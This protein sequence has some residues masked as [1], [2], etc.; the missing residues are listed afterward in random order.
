MILVAILAAILDLPNKT[1]LKVI[2][3]YS[4]ELLICKNPYFDTNFMKL[5]ALEQ[6]LWAFIGFGGHLG[7]KIT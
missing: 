7:F 2:L 6:K 1:W 3:M 5:S 4:I